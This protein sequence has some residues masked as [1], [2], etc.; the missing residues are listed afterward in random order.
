LLALGLGHHL[1]KVLLLGNIV[2]AKLE[3]HK[4]FLRC[5]FK[6]FRSRPKAYVLKRMFKPCLEFS[7]IFNFH[8]FI[9]KHGLENYFVRLSL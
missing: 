9:I 1:A 5:F 4:I 6:L 2:P 7:E 8:S 3:F